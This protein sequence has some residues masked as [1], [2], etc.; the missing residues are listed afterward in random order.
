M[1]A[2]LKSLIARSVS[3][4][5]ARRLALALCLCSLLVSLWAYT[6]S[7]PLPLLIVLLNLATLVVV[8]LQQW[9]S[10]KSIKFQPQELADRL[11]QV[12]E[13]ER[14]RLSRELHDDIG[15]LLTAAKLQSEWLK[16]R[17]P[18]DL[19]SQCTVLC[20]TCLLYTSPSPRD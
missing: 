20:N 13:N 5:N 17:L 11:L 18:D 2:S 19:Q 15:Q 9:R 6:R 12:Q 1:Y 16:R 8:G 7:A 10:R 3:R 4:S 14:H